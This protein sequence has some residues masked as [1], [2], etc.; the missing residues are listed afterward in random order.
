MEAL[1]EGTERGGRALSVVMALK[2]GAERGIQVAIPI[3]A[4]W[5]LERSVVGCVQ[6]VAK[7]PY[8][9]GALRNACLLVE[10]LAALRLPDEEDEVCGEQPPPPADHDG[11]PLLKHA[12]PF[13]ST[14]HTGENMGECTETACLLSWQQSPQ[15]MCCI[16][17]LPA[18]LAAITSI[19]VLH[20]CAA[21]SVGSN[22][23]N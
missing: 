6:A 12:Q 21:C 11:C 10:R 22:H 17:A 16:F 9:V 7:L 8:A 23:L 4:C 5:R 14:R 1:K 2:G 20:I 19:D 15:L 18:Q 13:H 3:A